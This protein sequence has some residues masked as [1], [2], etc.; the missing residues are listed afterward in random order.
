MNLISEVPR[1]K[2]KQKYRGLPSVVYGQSSRRSESDYLTSRNG[3]GDVHSFKSNN[4]FNSDYE[5]Y[6]G[7]LAMPK[8]WG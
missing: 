2:D 5:K 8:S 7:R 1:A 6:V 3:F 4:A